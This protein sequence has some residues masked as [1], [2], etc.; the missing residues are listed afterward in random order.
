MRSFAVKACQQLVEGGS[1]MIQSGKDASQ[2][3][4]FGLDLE[5]FAGS[6]VLGVRQLLWGHESGLQRRFMP[7]ACLKG[8]VLQVEEKDAQSFGLSAHS[9]EV[10]GATAVLLPDD[11]VLTRRIELPSVAEAELAAIAVLEAEANSPFSKEDTS[12]GWRVLSREA[13]HLILI[14][15]ISSRRAI[16]SH[17]DATR[18]DFLSRLR[19]V[20]VWSNCEG[21]LVQFLGFGEAQRKTEYIAT[22]ARSA[23]KV[24]LLALAVAAIVWW[25]AGALSIKERQLKE[26]LVETELRAGTA[27]AARNSLIDMEDRLTAASEFYADRLLYDRWLD[28][29]AAL[30][31]D[32]AYLTSMSFD[33]DRLTISGQAANAAALQTT[34][35]NA[36]ILSEVTAP[37]AFTRDN[38]TGRERFT[39]TMQLVKAQQ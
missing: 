30:T 7:K 33:K 26:M 14:L 27:T 36:G 31:P 34:L 11:L 23:A 15:T 32:S 17:L 4:L 39:L 22:L 8:N 20:E 10:A 3:S 18:A 28:Q 24:G 19:E 35:A 6:V 13:S 9:A 1:K 16:D 2:W 38:R 29:M 21:K 37:S 12:F 25:P 5:R